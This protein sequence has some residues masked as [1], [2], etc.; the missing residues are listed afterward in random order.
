MGA[1]DINQNAFPELPK[2]KAT[3]R[4]LYWEPIH[5]SGERITFAILIKHANGVHIQ[6]VLRPSAMRALY[7]KKSAGV[8]GFTELIA[9]SL[10]AHLEARRSPNRWNPPISGMHFGAWREAVSDSLEGILDQAV[11]QVSSLSWEEV[12]P[13]LGKEKD[14]SP[15]ETGRKNLISQIK[16]VVIEKRI[17]LV[18]YFDREARLIDNG[19][20]V[21]F[22]FLSDRIVA[23]FGLLR[24]S[25]I[26]RSYKDARGR[27]WELQKAKERAHFS[28]ASLILQM[29]S[30]D[31]LFFDDKQLEASDA[32]LYELRTEAAD[33]DVLVM[34]VHTPTQAADALIGIAVQ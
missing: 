27:L 18:P 29:P 26:G 14:S 28:A 22:G 33:E 16:D 7:G 3:W 20:P 10:R 23:H 15:Q 19:I 31:D 2:Y 6:S 34:N 12:V 30:K 8:R 9:D 32:A 17:D 5:A 13:T 11:H 1:N 4:P 21:R 25:E 24:P